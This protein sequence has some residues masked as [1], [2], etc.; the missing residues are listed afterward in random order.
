M[1]SRGFTLIELMVTIVMIMLVGSAGFLYFY[2]SQRA[3]AQGNLMA[4]MQDNARMAMDILSRSFRETGYMIN[5]ADYPSN[6]ITIGGA[7]YTQKIV[8]YNNYNGAGADRAELVGLS[9]GIPKQLEDGSSNK[10]V[11]TSGGLR[12]EKSI[13]IQGDVRTYLPAGKVVSFGYVSSSAVEG[14]PTFD[15]ASTAISLDQGLR[16]DCPVN[17]PIYD[18]SVVTSLEIRNDASTDNKPVLYMNNN[19]LAENIEDLQ[20]KYGIDSN[21]DGVVADTE[22]KDAPLSTDIDLIRLV[23]ITVVARTSR[24]IEM[25]KG[26]KKHIDVEDH[27]W[28]GSTPADGYSR[29]V[30]TRVVKCRNFI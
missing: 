13:I 15:G 19:P 21:A 3:S 6:K 9:N 11:M 14:T 23:R 28:P 20:F 17:A 16:G 1:K 26:Q 8:T 27:T 22:W 24:E 25:L 2:G 29:F 30:L 4:E 18:L 12:G 10:I 5:F 7:D